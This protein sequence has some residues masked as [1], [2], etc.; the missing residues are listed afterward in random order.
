MLCFLFKVTEP[1]SQTEPLIAH[2]ASEPSAQSPRWE[3][4]T[5]AGALSLLF[6]GTGQLFNRQPRKALLF[7]IV[8]HLLGVSL[9]YTRW[10]LTFRGM[11][12]ILILGGAWKICVVSDAVY[13]SA[14]AQKPESPVPVPKLA[15]LLLSAM[16]VAGALLPS[17]DT[18][19][20]KS[21]F[22]AF[23]IPSSSMCPTICVGDRIVVDAYSYRDRAPQRG[24]IIVMKHA[25]SEAFFLKRVIGLP[26]DTIAPGDNGSVLVNGRQFHPPAACIPVSPQKGPSEP[27]SFNP[28]RVPEGTLFVVGDNLDNSFDS[29]H[30]DFGTVTSAMVRGKPLYLY[31]S[32]TLAR[33]GCEVH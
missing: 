29:R 13:A 7:G 19:K 8:S 33:I 23:V 4:A 2:F 6:S 14:R 20:R 12:A 21:G 5:A 1:T 32:P 28:I 26:G 9:A 27:I 3:R 25:S 11:L 24:D 30:P 16:L 22:G 31:W 17:V 15:Y 18:V 10:L